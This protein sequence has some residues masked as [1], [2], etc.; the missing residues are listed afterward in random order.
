MLTVPLCFPWWRS[1]LQT[2][3]AGNFWLRTFTDSQYVYQ[4]L[5][6]PM[7]RPAKDLIVESSIQS[8]G[9]HLDAQKSS[10]DFLKGFVR[11]LGCIRCCG[12]VL[13]HG[14]TASHSCPGLALPA[15][16]GP[17]LPCL[18]RPGHVYPC[19]PLPALACPCL[20]RPVPACPCLSLPGLPCGCLPAHRPLGSSP[21]LADP[22]QNCV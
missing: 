2:T 8:L 16:A 21:T 20:L 9:I 19:L 10:A 11:S 22:Q 3:A 6:A 12:T 4:F 1:S 13:C 15:L 17:C 14:G 5:E 7:W 18:L